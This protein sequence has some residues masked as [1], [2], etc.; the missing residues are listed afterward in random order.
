[1]TILI[2]F[3]F[4]IIQDINTFLKKNCY[5]NSLGSS[6]IMKQMALINYS[7]NITE[8]KIISMEE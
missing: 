4:R 3:S 5:K 1:M 8:N 6:T 7:E 2:H